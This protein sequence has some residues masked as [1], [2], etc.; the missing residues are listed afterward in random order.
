M[1][2]SLS[3][4]ALLTFIRNFKYV[5]PVTESETIADKMCTFISDNSILII[6]N[7]FCFIWL[8]MALW[9]Y[10]SFLV[11]KWN[12]KKNG[13]EI[14]NAVE[15][16]DAGLNFFMTMIIPLLLDDISTMQGALTFAIIVLLMCALLERTS[17]F[18]AN[19]V[20]ALLGYR[21]YKFQFKDNEEFKNRT[22][23]GVVQGTLGNTQKSVEYKMISGNVLY[24]KEL[25]N[26]KGTDAE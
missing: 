19:P 24:V 15:E 25:I 1:I 8:V 11:F 13:Y 14:C 10:I 6:V 4:L 9:S 12:D 3:P 16:E 7:G 2:Q 21:V 20:L 26:D 23:I 5:L 18:Y 17:L 22:C